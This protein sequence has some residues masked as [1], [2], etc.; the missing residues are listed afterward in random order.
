M[1]PNCVNDIGSKLYYHRNKCLK[2]ILIKTSLVTK[3]RQKC[4]GVCVSNK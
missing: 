3:I 1:S 4:G 2:L